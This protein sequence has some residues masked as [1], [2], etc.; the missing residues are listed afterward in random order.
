ML[1]QHGGFDYLWASDLGGGNTDTACT[2]RST[3]QTDVESAVIRAIS[4]GGA[5]PLIPAQ[6]IDVLHVNHHGSESSTNATWMN[7]AAPAVAVISVGGGQSASW[8]LPRI[9]VVDK[10]L[11]G[12]ASRCVTAPPALVLQ[13]EDGDPAGAR[14]SFSG[15]SVGDIRIATDGRRDFHVYADGHVRVGMSEVGAAGLPRTFA[16]DT[17][18]M[19][20]DGR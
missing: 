7:L 17:P 4:P 19:G 5:A 8:E 1:I 10:V 13:T 6:G 9:D 3:A 16:L 11:L 12:Q 2:G 20:G 18:M 14:T 15:F